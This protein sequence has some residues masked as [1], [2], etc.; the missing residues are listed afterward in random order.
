MKHTI[1]YATTV[2]VIFDP[3]GHNGAG[4]GD[5]DEL[6]AALQESWR[7]AK[8]TWLEEGNATEDRIVHFSMQAATYDDAEAFHLSLD[9]AA[10]TPDDVYPIIPVV[11]YDED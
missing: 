4:A 8:I 2:A 1:E 11:V 9:D 5:P 3:N 10:P 7:D 6:G